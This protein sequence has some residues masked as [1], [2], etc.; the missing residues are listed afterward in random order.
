MRRR[1]ILAMRSAVL[2]IPPETPHEEV[3]VEVSEAPKE[4]LSFKGLKACPACG[5]EMTRGLYLYYMKKHK[6]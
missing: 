5:K 1:Q 4:V 3:K 2:T 6:K